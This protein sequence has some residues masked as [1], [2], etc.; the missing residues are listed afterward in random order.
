MVTVA[1]L[2]S[3]V[4]LISGAF[5]VGEFKQAIKPTFNNDYVYYRA[6]LLCRVLHVSACS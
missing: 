2:F 6:T 3:C 5:N 1:F 4:G